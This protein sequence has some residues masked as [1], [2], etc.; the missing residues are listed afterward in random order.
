MLR[1]IDHIPQVGALYFGTMP[2]DHHQPRGHLHHVTL[3][4]LF[5]RLAR[6]VLAQKLKVGLA[7]GPGP[8]VRVATVRVGLDGRVSH[9]GH[10]ARAF[11]QA[12]ERARVAVKVLALRA[13]AIVRALRVA[14]QAQSSRVGLERVVGVVERAWY[15]RAA[16]V[17]AGHFRHVAIRHVQLLDRDEIVD[18]H[19]PADHV[20]EGRATRSFV[21]QIPQIGGQIG[22][23]HDRHRVV[24]GRVGHGAVVLGGQRL[25][26]EVAVGSVGVGRVQRDQIGQAVLDHAHAF[27]GARATHTVQVGLDVA[28]GERVLHHAALVFLKVGDD[29]PANETKRTLV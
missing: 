24:H 17:L 22:A 26:A 12:P 15:A 2:A 9:K 10:V 23:L 27:P 28:R 5:D 11:V 13:R 21:S 16:K 25:Q 7:V 6:A 14:P 4:V 3:G 19:V 29:T 1:E 18:R 8:L 20:A